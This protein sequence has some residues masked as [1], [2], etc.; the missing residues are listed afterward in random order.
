MISIRT[1]ISFLAIVTVGAVIITFC[2]EYKDVS[3]KLLAIEDT[4]HVTNKIH[5]I[6]GLIHSLQKERGL[7]VNHLLGHNKELHNLYLKQ[8]ETTK[9]IWDKLE[10]SLSIINKINDLNNL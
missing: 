9:S 10:S 2:L 6:S 4:Q 7:S 8:C 5:A 3:K 1:R